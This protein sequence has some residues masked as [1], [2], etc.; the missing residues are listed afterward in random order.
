[1]AKN[2]FQMLLQSRKFWALITALTAIFTSLTNGTIVA[3]DAV[4]AIVASLAAY[5]I[6]TGIEDVNL[7]G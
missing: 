1:M 2:K 4:T 6:A 3:T 7:S 5:M